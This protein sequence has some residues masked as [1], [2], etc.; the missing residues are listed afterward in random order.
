ML[1]AAAAHSQQADTAAASC[2]PDTVGRSTVSY[3]TIG[4]APGYGSDSDSSA[5]LIALRAADVIR[6]HFITPHSISLPMWARYFADDNVDAPPT[7]ALAHGLATDVAF[8]LKP[9]GRLADTII[10]VR[11]ASPEL[12]AAIEAAVL[13]A[14]SA[15]AFHPIVLGGRPKG[16]RLV[17][18]LIA[19]QRRLAHAVPLVRLGVPKVKA[20]EGVEVKGIPRPRYPTNA[21][22]AGVSSAV[23]LQYVVTA[24][25]NADPTSFRIIRADY[26]EFVVEAMNALRRGTYRPA[27]LGA[28]PI[29]MLVQQRVSFYFR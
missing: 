24:E 15:G 3:E 28:C 23:D 1:S 9:D 25:G 2:I 6:E 5:S 17:L 20:D 16:G 12:N 7:D 26:K 8:R 4:L 10:I 27:K 22:L 13:A 18:R 21:E 14:D 29:P 11:T 19:W